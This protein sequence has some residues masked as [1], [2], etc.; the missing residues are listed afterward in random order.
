M[1]RVRFRNYGSLFLGQSL[2]EDMQTT[3]QEFIIESSSHIQCPYL[4]TFTSIDTTMSVS[5]GII[6]MVLLLLSCVW[7]VVVLLL[8]P[9]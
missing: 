3:D 9:S 4:P 7:V 1:S 6:V 2:T 8:S 5:L